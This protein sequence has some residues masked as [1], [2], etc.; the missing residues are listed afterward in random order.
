MGICDDSNEPQRSAHGPHCRPA[1][2]STVRC[3]VRAQR[4]GNRHGLREA[5][6]SC[7][8]VSRG[9]GSRHGDRIGHRVCGAI[10]LVDIDERLRLDDH[11]LVEILVEFKERLHRQD[12]VLVEVLVEVLVDVLTDE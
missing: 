2:I 5:Y 3:G 7:R 8:G 9:P 11:V 4:K 6:R 10:E 1:G 12:H